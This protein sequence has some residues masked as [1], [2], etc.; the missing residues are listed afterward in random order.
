MPY[1]SSKSNFN[2]TLTSIYENSLCVLQPLWPMLYLLYW[3]NCFT[4]L[5]LLLNFTVKKL[6]SKGRLY[7]KRGKGE[8]EKSLKV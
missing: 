5:H 4:M 3:I 8:S 1:F 2:Q 6:I 7:N